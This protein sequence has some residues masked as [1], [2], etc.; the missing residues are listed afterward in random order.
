MRPSKN[1]TI[2]PAWWMIILS[3]GSS[4]RSLEKTS[5]AWA[6]LVALERQCGRSLAARVNYAEMPRFSTV[7]LAA[8][9]ALAPALAR[10]DAEQPPRRWYGWPIMIAD[11]C[12]RRADARP[13]HGGYGHGRRRSGA[14]HSRS[15]GVR[16]GPPCDP[17]CARLLARRA[18]QLRRAHRPHRA[19]PFAVR[20]HHTAHR[21]RR[22][23]RPAGVS[24]VRGDRFRGRNDRRLG[25]LLHRAGAAGRHRTGAG[26][27][28]PW[29]RAGVAV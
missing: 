1:G 27:G 3:P 8:S 13:R 16:P 26:A 20:G 14:G 12:R 5:R 19:R 11:G 24:A 7:F 17:P 18:S 9:L 29:T 23:M 4:S 25:S 15:I 21:L 28:W 2:P 22:R 6:T 10:G